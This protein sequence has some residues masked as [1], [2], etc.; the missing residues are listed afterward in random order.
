MNWI[1]APLNLMSQRYRSVNEINNDID[2]EIEFHI[3][4]RMEDLRAEGMTHQQA[5]TAARAAF[6]SQVSVRRQCQRINYGMRIWLNRIAILTLAC[7][8]AAIAFLGYQLT[9]E[10][11]RNR[12]L[13]LEL[14]NATAE[15][16]DLAGQVIGANGI[17]IRNASVYMTLKT[18]PDGRF[19]QEQ[20]VTQTRQDGRFVY[21]RLLPNRKTF[22]VHVAVMKKGFAFETCYISKRGEVSRPIK[23]LEIVMQPAETTQIQIEWTP[24]KPAADLP[25]TILSRFDG[26]AEHPIYDLGR[27][28]TQLR[29]N[30]NG[31]LDIPF[32]TQ[33]DE[34]ELGFVAPGSDQHRSDHIALRSPKQT[35]I[36]DSEN[37]QNSY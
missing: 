16:G 5:E 36:I 12:Q 13:L 23:P 35:Y 33:S 32:V 9:N 3:Q 27:H 29:T 31:I 10:R 4:C 20:F 15:F 21:E 37:E 6:G 30:S 34:L 2:D 19:L 7:C 25:V 18:W 26:T 14:E 8:L 24:G 17:P 1:A 22:E 11:H 28:Q